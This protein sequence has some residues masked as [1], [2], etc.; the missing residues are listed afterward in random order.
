M[1]VTRSPQVALLLTHYLL[2]CSPTAPLQQTSA[3]FAG[4]YYL[5]RFVNR[6]LMTGVDNH[7]HYDSDCPTMC[8]T[9]PSNSF[10][11]NFVSPGSLTSGMSVTTADK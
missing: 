7:W 11:C 8:R 1:T 10:A 3:Y 6:W 4:D 5:N 9:S 2:C